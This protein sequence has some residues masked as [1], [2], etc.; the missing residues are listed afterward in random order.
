MGG[1][2]CDCCRTMFYPGDKI[3]ELC[4]VC[5]NL[6]YCVL[7]EYDNDTRE[8]AAIFHT[9]EGAEEFVEANT[10]LI[11]KYNKYAKYKIIHSHITTWAVL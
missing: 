4:S 9:R 5:A 10:E 1:K 8:L 2:I 11:K 3:Y 6:V 7:Y